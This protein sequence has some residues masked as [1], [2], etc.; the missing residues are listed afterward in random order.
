MKKTIIKLITIIEC[1]WWRVNAV[2][3]AMFLFPII[4]FGIYIN[5]Y[6]SSDWGKSKMA[7]IN[8]WNHHKKRFK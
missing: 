5:M 1:F 6:T 3:G 4:K 8:S 7:V 2:L